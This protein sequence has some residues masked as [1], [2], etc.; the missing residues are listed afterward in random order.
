MYE[1]KKI[2][3]KLYNELGGKKTAKKN[4]KV[5]K[6]NIDEKKLNLLRW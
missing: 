3:P 2:N 6:L 5:Y 1:I 4:E